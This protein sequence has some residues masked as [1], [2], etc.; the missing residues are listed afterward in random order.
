MA[1]RLI[2]ND[3]EGIAVTDHEDSF[4]SSPAEFSQELWVL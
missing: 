4:D 1:N 3:N 2:F